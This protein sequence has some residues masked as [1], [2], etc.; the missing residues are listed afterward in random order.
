MR[1][2]DPNGDGKI[3]KMEFRQDIRKLLGM[4]T[5]VREIDA[6]FE[7]LDADSGGS[8]DAS[9]LK[10]ALSTLQECAVRAERDGVAQRERAAAYRDLSAEASRV[11]EAT[12]L[13]EE[14]ARKLEAATNKSPGAQLGSIMTE[15]GIRA[16]DVVA[17]WDRSGDG[18][19]DKKEFRREVVALGVEATPSEIDAL[20]ESLDGDGGGS[21]DLKE[22]RVALKSLQDQAAAAKLGYRSVC[23]DALSAIRHCSAAHEKHRKRAKAVEEE[24]R[25]RA[26]AAAREL[27][28]RSEAKNAANAANAA[29]AAQKAAAAAADKAAFDAK[30]AAKRAAT[31]EGGSS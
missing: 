2:W 24:E 13:A 21:L 28:G 10:L 25:A 12:R 1:E 30:I 26:D 14:H 7:S 31:K 4:E 9:E 3:S 20:F 5:D 22:L 11:A 8:L 15:K 16:A 6:L 27:Q 19:I 29:A 23:E 17:K 18:E